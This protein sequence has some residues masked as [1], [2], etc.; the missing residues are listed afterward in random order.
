MAWWRPYSV[1]E[2]PSLLGRPDRQRARIPHEVRDPTGPAP[3]R[4]A[5]A[6]RSSCFSSARE[7]SCTAD[8][9]G[10]TRVVRSELRL[11]SEAAQRIA[12]AST[13][14]LMQPVELGTEVEL[15]GGRGSPR[16][17]KHCRMSPRP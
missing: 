9:C 2:Q 16:S 6:L 14:D 12:F 1:A 5:D 4:D 10:V 11:T 7:A 15:Q 13:G 8:L 17:C 3:S